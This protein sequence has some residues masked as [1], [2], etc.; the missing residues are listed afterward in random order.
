MNIGPKVK[1]LIIHKFSRD[2]TQDGGLG[3][4]FNLFKDPKT[5]SEKMKKA[6]EWVLE[7]IQSVKDAPNNPYGDDS[8]AIAK[9]ILEMMP[10]VCAECGKSKVNLGKH[11]LKCLSCET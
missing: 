1:A 6:Q 3:S 2:A 8:E 4:V 9:A 7:Q 5:L 10:G 11:G